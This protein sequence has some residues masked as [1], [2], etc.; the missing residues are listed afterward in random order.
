MPQYVLECELTQEEMSLIMDFCTR[1]FNSKAGGFCMFADNDLRDLTIDE[2][3]R[4]IIAIGIEEPE[5]ELNVPDAMVAFTMLRKMQQDKHGH[6][7]G[8]SSYS[9][10]SQFT[11][12]ELDA[13]L[14]AVQPQD[15][16]DSV[17]D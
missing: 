16:S 6:E 17:E 8:K 7:V 11:R 1:A 14:N 15:P 2:L 10:R 13:F 12:R 5:L 3:R 4:E 9:I